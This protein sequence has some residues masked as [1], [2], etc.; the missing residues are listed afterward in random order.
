MKTNIKFIKYRFG[1]MIFSLIIISAG[2]ISFFYQGFNYSIDFVGGYRIQV[3]FSEKIN[4]I[5]RLNIK[6]NDFLFIFFLPG[7][8]SIE[9]KEAVKEKSRHE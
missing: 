6:K 7:K 1:G 4:I 2:L 3:R 8:E 5:P 9:N